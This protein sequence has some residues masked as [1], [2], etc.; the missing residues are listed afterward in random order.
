MHI[1]SFSPGVAVDICVQQPRARYSEGHSVPILNLVDSLEEGLAL[2]ENDN[3]VTL[4]ADVAGDF[5]PLVRSAFT[6][7]PYPAS[8]A[9]YRIV[10][11]TSSHSLMYPRL[12]FIGRAELRS[13]LSTW[14]RD[15]DGTPYFVVAGRVGM[16]KSAAMAQLAKDVASAGQACAV[17]FCDPSN[18]V[19]RNPVAAAESLALGLTSAVPRYTNA[20]ATS[21]SRGGVTISGAASAQS[22]S[23]TQVGVMIQELVINASAEEA[24]RALLIK[25]LALAHESRRRPVIL[26][27]DG[28]DEA[29]R[30]DGPTH[31]SDLIAAQ[32]STDSGVRYVLSTRLPDEL[33]EQLGRDRVT[34]W[35][36]SSN[37]RLA[38]SQRDVTA[39]LATAIDEL[40]A[41]GKI[42]SECDV[43]ALTAVTAQRSEANFLYTRLFIDMVRVRREPFAS[44]D[45]DDLPVGLGPAYHQALRHVLGTNEDR[46][47]ERY[48]PVLGTLSIAQEPLLASQIVTFSGVRSAIVQSV[49][50]M[51]EPFLQPG[52]GPPSERLYALYHTAFRDFLAERD[53]AERW[54][55]DSGDAHERI[56]SAYCNATRDWQDDAWGQVDAYGLR[57]V[58]THWRC[59]DRPSRDLDALATTAFFEA[60]VHRGGGLAARDAQLK[61]A[62]D[63]AIS[64]GDA[65]RTLRWSWVRHRLQHHLN[66]QLGLGAASLLVRAGRAGTLDTL[67][68]MYSAT[69][70]ARRAL[71]QALGSEDKFDLAMKVIGEAISERERLQLR[72]RLAESIARKDPSR[73]VELAESAMFTADELST[74]CA[75]VAAHP[76]YVDAAW[77]LASNDGP[78]QTAVVC[79]VATVD[80]ERA[81]NLAARVRHYAEKVNGVYR[82]MDSQSVLA[83]VCVLA[84]SHAPELVQRILRDTKF[85]SSEQARIAFTLVL[86]RALTFAHARDV[87]DSLHASD[88]LQLLVFAAAVHSWG[89]SATADAPR[90]NSW[91]MSPAADAPRTRRVCVPHRRDVDVLARI[92]LERLRGDSAAAE[93]ARV[94]LEHVVDDV[95]REPFED[96]VTGGFA[97]LAGAMSLF[98]VDASVKLAHDSKDY[99][100]VMEPVVLSGIVTRLTRVD[101]E[102]GWEVARAANMHAPLVAWAAA[103]PE[104]DVNAAVERVASIDERYS[105]TRAALAAEL[106]RKLRSSDDGSTL[107]RLLTRPVESAR[108]ENERDAYGTAAARAVALAGLDCAPNKFVSAQPYM[109]D[110]RDRKREVEAI[111]AS[112]NAV[113]RPGS[114]SDVSTAIAKATALARIGQRTAIDVTQQL[115]WALSD[116]VKEGTL[117][118]AILADCAIGLLH[119]RGALQV[120]RDL[121]HPV[122][123]PLSAGQPEWPW[124]LMAL[125]RVRSASPASTLD[126]AQMFVVRR[127]AHTVEVRLNEEALGRIVDLLRWSEPTAGLVRILREYPT[128]GSSLDLFMR[129]AAGSLTPDEVTG[130]LESLDHEDR[131]YLLARLANSKP[132]DAIGLCQPWLDDGDATAMLGVLASVAAVDVSDA[133]AHHGRVTWSSA[134]ADASDALHAI[135]LVAART[136][137]DRGLEIVKG[138]PHRNVVGLALHDFAALAA[139]FEDPARSTSCLKGVLATATEFATGY[140]D[141]VARGLLGGMTHVRKPDADLLSQMC[142]FIGELEDFERYL[143][144]LA[145]LVAEVCDPCELVTEIDLVTHLLS[146]QT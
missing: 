129:A 144:P 40:A 26:L 77:R 145:T 15:A 111:L 96:D 32:S 132:M 39:F 133:L 113:L 60:V 136:N 117:E 107:L 93:L 98:D 105:A 66:E 64:R 85:H 92:E 110:T 38:E 22:V 104:A 121:D 139:T 97:V 21:A 41:D 10:P 87:F 123:H 7:S 135:A 95:L 11:V 94:A 61:V 131:C 143:G 2:D 70:S 16:G 71:V 68:P 83:E 19:T 82:T 44:S 4:L 3:V 12:D 36:L 115:A 54:Y 134:P 137:W 89:L 23:G 142:R 35:D 43:Q 37:G 45:I 31:L 126:G 48:E 50:R 112:E 29:D 88:A 5:S 128:V 56:V 52:V 99:S 86:S 17:H 114:L 57:H 122:Y 118:Q 141:Y 146:V 91:G 124:L 125:D 59:A 46:W 49:L 42:A 62:I 67:D 101:A 102:A 109:R 76:A 119:T 6:G 100:G 72:G 53:M 25:P 18:L 116:V 47:L 33:L 127:A 65:L 80:T 51:I 8:S 73:A 58:L 84:V 14:L 1:G 27:I 130:A 78:A 75:A 106:A 69:A 140:E 90:I 120:A 30:F 13:A 103:L 9:S 20:L 74:L 24:W 34:L 108:F 55:C 138:I 63:V 28:L 81:I 79:A